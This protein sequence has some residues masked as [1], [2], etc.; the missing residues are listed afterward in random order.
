M[1]VCVCVDINYT[2]RCVECCIPVYKQIQ[3]C[4]TFVD[5]EYKQIHRHPYLFDLDY[6]QI[7]RYN[8]IIIQR[9]KTISKNKTVAICPGRRHGR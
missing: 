6:T 4:N 9:I 2:I 3:R 8:K 5:L 7:H 1:R